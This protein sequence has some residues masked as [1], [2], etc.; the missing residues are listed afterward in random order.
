MSTDRVISSK[1]NLLGRDVGQ[2]DVLAGNLRGLFVQMR[3]EMDPLLLQHDGGFGLLL[4]LL[5]HVPGLQ[6]GKL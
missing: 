3:L 2:D 6:E 1:S 4:L 5:H